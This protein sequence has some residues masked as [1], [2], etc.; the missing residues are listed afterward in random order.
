MTI[1]SVTEAYCDK[2]AAASSFA[3]GLNSEESDDDS[4]V[5]DD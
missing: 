5:D 4:T 3:P 2:V 1:V